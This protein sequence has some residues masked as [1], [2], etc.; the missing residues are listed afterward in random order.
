MRD[1]NGG[2]PCRCSPPAPHALALAWSWEV[3]C[4][5]IAAVGS[6]CLLGTEILQE[7]A[8]GAKNHGL[9]TADEAAA[10]DEAAGFTPAL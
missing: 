3:V 8:T 10:E 9:K 1:S 7:I 5:C 2:A 6:R 4:T